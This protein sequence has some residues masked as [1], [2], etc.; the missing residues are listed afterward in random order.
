LADVLTNHVNSNPLCIAFAESTTTV[1]CVGILSNSKTAAKE[2]YDD[3]IPLLKLNAADSTTT[4]DSPDEKIQNSYGLRKDSIDPIQQR[5]AE[6]NDRTAEATVAR[7]LRDVKAKIRQLQQDRDEALANSSE[8]DGNVRSIRDELLNVQQKLAASIS[9]SQLQ[10]LQQSLAAKHSQMED[11]LTNFQSRFR[12]EVH[13]S[14]NAYLADVKSS[15]SSLEAYLIANTTIADEDDNEHYYAMQSII[16]IP[17]TEMETLQQNGRS[18][19]N[20]TSSNNNQRC[21]KSCCCIF[22]RSCL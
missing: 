15:F 21:S 10:V 20:R 9:T 17:N 16:T 5:R 22:M 8:V 19:V 12:D 18:S 6:Q 7:G 1:W 3:D 14:V 11:D 4:S 2:R 13:Q